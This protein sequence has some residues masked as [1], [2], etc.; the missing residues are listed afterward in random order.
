MFYD[1]ITYTYELI[2]T[3]EKVRLYENEKTN[4]TEEL[5]YFH[6]TVITTDS[7]YQVLA[8]CVTFAPPDQVPPGSR[9]KVFV[10]FILR[11]K[12][13]VIL[14][15]FQ[16]QQIR[17]YLNMI[18]ETSNG[19]HVVLYVYNKNQGIVP[20]CSNSFNIRINE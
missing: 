20:I 16:I 8:S 10:V 13:N 12:L 18:K 19:N 15:L 3:Y 1:N 14:N 17:L 2:R 11:V 5:A 7:G 9:H 4:T 6:P